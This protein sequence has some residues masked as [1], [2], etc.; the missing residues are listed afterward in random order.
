[1]E[2]TSNNKNFLALEDI[3]LNIEE[4][5]FVCIIGPSGCG[6]STLLSVLEGLYTP[7][8]GD[9]RINGIPVDGPGRERA[10]VFQHYSLFPWL[11]AKKNVSFSI[12]QVNK[13]I[14]KT[15]ADEISVEY[16]KKVGLE[17]FIEK[18]PGELSGGMQQRVAIARALAVSPEILLM[19][20]PFGAV[21]AKT[22][23]VLQE[24]LLNL[25]ESDGRRMTV[26]FVTHDIDE[27]LLLSD[28][29]IFMGPKHIRCDIPVAF[30]RPREKSELYA[31][32]EYAKLRVE[33]VNMFY[34]DIA[35]KIDIEGGWL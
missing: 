32:E 14:K 26:V 28:R 27:A 13:N 30:P 21:D 19:D 3:N 18:L 9:V 5:Q 31:T 20:E 25:W 6:K 7:T 11:T 8:G 1:M 10:V 34:D 23:V 15:R 17:D 12:A 35:D 22:R 33:L 29:I 24:L 16:L 4:G 2:Y